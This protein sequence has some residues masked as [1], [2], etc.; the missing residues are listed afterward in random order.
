MRIGIWDNR[1]KK[2]IV[3]RDISIKEAAGEYKAYDLGVHE[4]SQGA[5]IWISPPNRPGEVDGVYIDRMFFIRE[6]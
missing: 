3:D 2:D 4:M 1:E 5:Q 6:K